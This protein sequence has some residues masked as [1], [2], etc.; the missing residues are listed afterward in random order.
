V[1]DL[2]VTTVEVW[3]DSESFYADM[4]A[5]IG[6]RYGGATGYVHGPTNLTI[7]DGANAA[8][9]AAHELAHC[10][11][12]RVSSTIGNNPRWLWETIAVYENGE[13]VDPRTLSYMQSGNCP[14]LAQLNSDYSG[15]RQVYET[16]YVLGEFIVS[17]W[18]RNGLVRLIQANG[19]VEKVFG[20]AT[21]LFEQQWAA[22][23]AQ[24]YLR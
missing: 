3:S 24:K 14:T 11:S 12:L 19:D 6:Q 1:S 4:A 9:R 10:I 5:T 13:S 22:F 15:G 2:P 16:G 7:L 18:G 23:V 21:A 8:G 20:L 17:T